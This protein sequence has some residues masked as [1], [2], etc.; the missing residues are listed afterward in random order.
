MRLTL[1]TM[2]AYLDDM[3]EPA[4]AQ[5]IAEK[6]EKSEFATDIVHRLRGAMQKLRLEAPA[7]TGKEMGI[8]PN[9][10]AEYLDFDLPEDRVPDFERFCLVQ[11]PTIKSEMHLA[12]VASCHQVLALVLQGPPEIGP[13]TRERM[14]GLLQP[15]PVPQKASAASTGEKADQRPQPAPWSEEHHKPEVPQE[16]REIRSA[17]RFWRIAAA[18]L[19]MAGL[20]LVGLM[21]AQ[22]E[23]ATNLFNRPHDRLASN[24]PP[25]KTGDGL[26]EADQALPP[27]ADWDEASDPDKDTDED[28]DGLKQPAD[29]EAADR[30]AV[31]EPLD[32]DPA[33]PLPDDDEEMPADEPPADVDDEPVG[34]EPPL[35]AVAEA[36]AP[37]DDVPADMPDKEPAQVPAEAPAGETIARYV[38]ANSVLARLNAATG[39]WDRLPPQEAITPG[40]R[41]LTF[42]GFDATIALT[43]AAT[44]Q[45]KGDTAIELQGLDE[46][47][48]LSLR[49]WH[50]RL[51]IS[52][53]GKAQTRIKL[54]AGDSKGMFTC[55]NGDSTV[56]IEVRP[57]HVEGVDPD[58]NP[59]QWRVDLYALSGTQILWSN[60]AGAM[61]EMKA[62]AHITAGNPLLDAE[63]PEWY[64]AA[65][66]N[67]IEKRAAEVVEGQLRGVAENRSTTLI[68]QELAQ[69]R[70]REVRSLAVRCLAAIGRFDPLWQTLSEPE[71]RTAWQEHVEALRAAVALG[72]D[73]STLVL[74]SLSGLRGEKDVELYRMLWG[75]SD[76]QLAAGD[77]DKLIDYLEHP[78]LDFRVLSYWNLKN[79]T[80]KSLSYRP[81]YPEAR[82]KQGVLQFRAL[83]SKGQIAY[84]QK[85]AAPK[86]TKNKPE[87]EPAP[88]NEGAE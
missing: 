29:I 52:T 9:T 33:A 2:L 8:D 88:G 14:Y 76:E 65:P 27:A 40:Q 71:Q 6:I 62:P 59:V 3:L 5:Q 23:W 1:R 38:S 43:N 45:L 24:N 87:E 72:P 83:A 67:L 48:V 7:L 81:E 13:R 58:S 75:Y 77:A 82:R 26:A 54:E 4:D 51:I 11:P 47:G 35:P 86:G 28:A 84:P 57:S 73:M 42:P 61:L 20:G 79:I 74:Q 15:V 66:A 85:A 50:G 21:A 63:A 12:E 56:A 36:D 22:P 69:D 78:D 60:A 49:I 41:L 70:R 80:G 10:V 34:D 53:V 46:E 25:V 17:S 39:E 55:G 19:L 44:L 32:A 68:L 30:P 37:A 64:S 31:D 16:L 18:L